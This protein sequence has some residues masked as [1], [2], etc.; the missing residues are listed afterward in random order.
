MKRIAVLTS[1]GD[2]PGMNAAIRAVV[3]TGI[4]RGWEIHGVQNGFAGLLAGKFQPL[5]ARDVSNIMQRGGTML[6]S[7]RCWEFK[8]AE[9]RLEGL[10]QLREQAIEALVVIGG[11][12]SQQ[13]A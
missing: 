1:G 8:T 10:R 3:R 2:A 6:G 4:D 12:G 5:G 11:N 9:G 13:G 7:A